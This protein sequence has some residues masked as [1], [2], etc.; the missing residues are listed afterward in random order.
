MKVLGV[1]VNSR[2]SAE[3]H[4]AAI[5]SACSKS[6]YATRVLKTHGMPTIALHQVFQAT[7][8]SNMLYCSSAWSGF[9]NTADRQRIDAF[10]RRSKRYGYCA[11]EVAAVA[12]Q[13]VAA[14]E[15]LLK[16]VLSNPHH[17]LHQLL[18]PCKN[19]SYNLRKRPHNRQLPTKGSQLQQSNFI[20]RTLYN[21]IY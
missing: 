1:I 10:I 12:E 2:L 6:L 4:V 8:L 17:T 5:M 21:D 16:R 13:F 14:D 15:A 3:D 18:P 20:T 19:T 9:C 7:V 11:E